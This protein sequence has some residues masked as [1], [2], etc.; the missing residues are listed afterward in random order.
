[1]GYFINVINFRKRCYLN[2]VLSREMT[3]RGP[4]AIGH[5][6]VDSDFQVVTGRFQPTTSRF[7]AE[8]G[9]TGRSQPT[10][11]RLQAE[12]WATSRSHPVTN[13][14]QFVMILKEKILKCEK[15][16]HRDPPPV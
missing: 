14:F 11:S 2:D 15:C 1:M 12:S 6:E 8:S 10:T 9:A 4:L 16:W 3:G 7:Q 5:F 13:C